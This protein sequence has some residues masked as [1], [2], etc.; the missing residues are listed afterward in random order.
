MYSLWGLVVALLAIAGKSA[1]DC[2]SFGYDFVNGG[3]P[4]CINTTS[5]SY[6]TFGTEFFGCQPSD[7]QGAVSP[8]LVDP[9]N[10]EYQ[11]SDIAVQPDGQ[12]M[13]SVC[14]VAGN[15][16][17]KNNMVSG[18][19]TAVIE[20][21]TFA[22][23]REF[24]IIAAPPVTISSTPTFTYSV[25][26]TPST[27]I[28]STVTSVFTTSASPSTITVPTITTTRTITTTPAQKTVTSTST[29][30]RLRTTRVFSKTVAITTITTSC[31]TQTP[32]KDP[33]CTIRPTKATLA[34]ANSAYSMLPRQW[35]QIQKPGTSRSG[36]GSWG[37][38]KLA[39]R[40]NVAPVDTGPDMCTTTF[41]DTAH[42]VMSTITST[43]STT[44][45]EII[46]ENASVTTTITPPPVT[47]NSGKARTTITVTAATPTRVRT[48]RTYVTSWTTSTVWATI[49][50]TV[51][52]PPP[53]WIC[54]TTAAH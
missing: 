27:T 5:T 9:N 32:S 54:A 52:V 28:T 2:E 40:D 7:V 10:D 29:I 17:T 37:G 20:G 48:T 11:C 1:A 26:I 42:A 3:G 44:S 53:G 33:T 21:L 45:T 25:T 31:Q 30:T 34:A 51:K 46:T 6:F 23:M 38:H 36:W 8:I 50:S 16:L 18:S 39:R 49:A 12:D 41:M 22:W 14:N 35:H 19:W 15:E 13:V 4:Y 43:A 47:V 24:S